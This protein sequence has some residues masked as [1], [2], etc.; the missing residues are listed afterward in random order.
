[1]AKTKSFIVQMRVTE[2]RDYVVEAKNED[3]AR[4]K[5]NRGDLLGEDN[6]VGETVDWQ[7]FNVKSND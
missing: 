5:G 1:M 2:I 7:V 4:A 3:D 6:T